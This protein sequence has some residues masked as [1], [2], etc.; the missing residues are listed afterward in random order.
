MSFY[1]EWKKMTTIFKILKFNCCRGNSLWFD[2]ESWILVGRD[3][4]Q[5]QTN[6]MAAH[7]RIHG[8]RDSDRTIFLRNCPRNWPRRRLPANR[9]ERHCLTTIQALVIL[10]ILPFNPFTEDFT[11]S[12]ATLNREGS[13]RA[14]ISQIPSGFFRYLEPTL[15]V[16][17]NF[18]LIPRES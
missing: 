18:L 15:I 10:R 5:D 7:T 8:A 14:I 2:D 16:F 6:N 3:V 13:S 1:N 9:S 17:S 12:L 4:S 11:R